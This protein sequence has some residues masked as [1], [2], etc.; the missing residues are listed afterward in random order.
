[1]KNLYVLL[2][3][4]FLLFNSELFAAS[5]DYYDRY[6]V[7]M[8][9]KNGIIVKEGESYRGPL[10]FRGSLGYGVDDNKVVNL[11]LSFD[12]DIERLYFNPEFILLVN[13]FS[14]IKF[15]VTAGVDFGV[16]N[17]FE[18]AF[19]TSEGVIF[20]LFNHLSV[21]LGVDNRFNFYSD[22]YIESMGLL[23]LI[24]RI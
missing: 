8:G 23:S 11:N 5:T 16:L 19:V 3:I 6:M 13:E 22:F 9:I 7:Y 18:S 17:K 21:L 10:F 20:D 12:R 15:F 1:M 2:T 14:S 4:A 24:I